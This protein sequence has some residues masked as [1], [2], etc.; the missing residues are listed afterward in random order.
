MQMKA[1]SLHS[2]QSRA[3]GND[4]KKHWT[5]RIPAKGAS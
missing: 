4:E 2:R 3:G 5:S 1:H